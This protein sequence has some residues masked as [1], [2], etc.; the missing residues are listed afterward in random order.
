M[1]KLLYLIFAIF[2]ALSFSSCE[3]KEPPARRTILV[4][5][6][7]K[8]NLAGYDNADIHEMLQAQIPADCRLLVFRSTR[9]GAPQLL[10][11][12]K[13]SLQTL[14][15]YDETTIAAD[16][17]TLVQVLADARKLVDSKLWGIVFWSHS[18]GWKG[19]VKAPDSSR[20]FGYENGQEIELPDLAAALRTAPPFEFIFFDSCYMGCVE[21][22][23]ELRDC[24]DYL[25]A[26]ACEVPMTG[27]PY[28]ATLP[29]LFKSQTLKGL[30][31]AIDINVDYYLDRPTE[32][33][34]STFALIDLK[35]M[36]QLAAA[37]A[38]VYANSHAPSEAP[39]LL[40]VS[41]TYKGLFVDFEDF[42]R[43]SAE[44]QS[45]LAG[46]RSALGEAILH[47]RHTSSLWGQV[48]IT[49]FCGLSVNP[50]PTNPDY[51]YRNISWYK[52]VI[53]LDGSEN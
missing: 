14:K 5:M 20:S 9:G 11:I 17:E 46:F 13:N 35:K 16:A 36:D 49:D 8:N 33:C 3:K 4:Y 25:V 47:E 22:A 29:S 48:P 32:R 30:T 12:T 39:Q 34:P 26:S 24:A 21:V 31:E 1:K 28:D 15:S 10:E 2:A 41:S 7:A 42:M 43:L 23:Y 44:S 40:S 45:E 38:R 6:A 18:T 51:N 52:D 27:M 50:D 37:S 19:A 53:A